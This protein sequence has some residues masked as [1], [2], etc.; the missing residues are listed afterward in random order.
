MTGPLL[1]A[2]LLLPYEGKYAADPRLDAI[3]KELPARTEAARKKLEDLLQVKVPAVEV[4]LEDAGDD[5]SGVFAE[6]ADGV[7]VLKTEYLVLGAFDLDKTLVHETFHCLQRARLG[8]RYDRVPEWAREGAA[9]YVA[10]QG[11]E[12]ARAL[13]AIAG[14]GG[15]AKL[16]NG[17]GGPHG[18]F[19]YYED[20]AAFERVGEALG[21]PMTQGREARGPE[22]VRKLLETEDAAKAVREVLGED[23]ATFE[24][25]SQKHAREVLEPLL[26]EPNSPLEAL[27]GAQAL[28]REGKDAEALE[29]VRGFLGRYRTE[30]SLLG[31]AVRLEV[32][33]LRRTGS[34]DHAVAARRAALDLTVYAP[35]GPPA[36]TAPPS[37]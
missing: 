5:R 30:A 13:A 29:A 6:S 19:D 16:V 24:A 25:L 36:P 3:R 1:L 11:P 4:R 9:L 7:I 10:G 8:K 27:R 18:L 33:L 23:M 14:P 17:L 32:E 35:P 21:H 31:D 20:V 2:L 26:K 37:R 28:A 34:P 15:M 12:R 22:L